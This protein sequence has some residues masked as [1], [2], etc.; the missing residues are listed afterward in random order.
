MREMLAA[1]ELSLGLP[2]GSLPPAT[3][4]QTQLWGA[5]LPINT[6]RVP[7]IWDPVGRVGVCGDWVAG[8]GSMQAAALSG[9]A[10]AQRIDAIRGRGPNDIADLAQ[11]LTTPFKAVQGQ[12]IGQF[13]AAGGTGT[14]VSQPPPAHEREQAQWRPAKQQ[15]QRRR[16]QAQQA[17][18][19]EAH[20]A[21][22]SQI[23][24]RPVRPSAAG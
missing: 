10:M 3:F 14:A 4:T 6:P 11:G 8:G 19:G 5:A 13:P 24:A 15:Q 12:E 22:L 16:R 21:G 1:F 9:R 20:P 2:P 23:L 7:C 18:A 17:V